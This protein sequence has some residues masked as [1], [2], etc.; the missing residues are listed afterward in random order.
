MPQ[1]GPFPTKDA[2]FNEY[3]NRVFPYLDV[4]RTRLHV[5]DPNFDALTVLME[6]WTSIYPQTQDPNLRTRTFIDD[7]DEVRKLLETL[8]RTIYGDIPRS[9]LT[10]ADR[11]TLNLPAPDRQPTARGAIG[12]APYPQLLPMGGGK[13]RIELRVQHD[14]SRASM[15]P[16]AHSIEMAYTVGTTPP[17]SP[18]SAAVHTDYK[19]A[20]RTFDLGADNPGKKLFAF[21]RWKNETDEGKSSPWSTLVQTV[22]A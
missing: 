12:T 8:L 14:R 13:V 21:F 19:K 9:A 17:A 1:G 10:A 2:E 7:K 11:E 3:V 18:L 5:S 4:N 6:R 22:I 16:L 20:I 15:H